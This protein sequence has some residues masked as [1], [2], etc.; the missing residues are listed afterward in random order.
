M[1]RLI[2]S[3]PNISKK[4]LERLVDKFENYELVMSSA[5]KDRLVEKGK[6]SFK[7]LRVSVMENLDFLKGKGLGKY[8]HIREPEL[9]DVTASGVKVDSED[10]PI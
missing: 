5:N 4:K 1:K 3:D 2:V 7:N 6:T 9:A 8:K 10:E